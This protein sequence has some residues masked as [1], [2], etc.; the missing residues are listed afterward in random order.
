MTCLYSIYD[1]NEIERDLEAE[2]Q[3]III[4]NEIVRRLLSRVFSKLVFIRKTQI[5]SREKMAFLTAMA[6]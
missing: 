1:L 5:R 4:A 6:F 3:Q 2:K